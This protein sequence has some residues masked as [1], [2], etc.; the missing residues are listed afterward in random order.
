MTD[1]SR[2][3]AGSEAEEPPRPEAEV[4]N[5]LWAGYDLAYHD[6]QETIG[7][8]AAKFF[9]LIG[10]AVYTALTR[11][12]VDPADPSL[13]T[14]LLKAFPGLS[15]I[16][17]A[18]L[19]QK[20][21]RAYKDGTSP[22]LKHSVDLQL[23]SEAMSRAQEALNRLQLLIDVLADATLPARVREYL[24]EVVHTFLFGFDA[25]S[26]ALARSAFEQMAREVL[27]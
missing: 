22:V 2:E 27:I 25:A 10:G 3:D 4:W 7:N 16:D 9:D 21:F 24:S 8:E 1:D 18:A 26:I 15:A 11:L 17:Q 19:F 12:F 20:L 5:H 14:E 6:L 23:A 13:T